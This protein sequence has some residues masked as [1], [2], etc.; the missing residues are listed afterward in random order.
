[1][2][3][4]KIFFIGILIYLLN[5]F[6]SY[7]NKKNDKESYNNHIKRVSFADENNKPLETFIKI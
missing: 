6:Y 1:M 3:L 7:F 2:S 5:I 4:L